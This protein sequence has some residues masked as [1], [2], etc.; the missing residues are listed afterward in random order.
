LLLRALT[1]SSYVHENPDAGAEDN[2]RLEFL[3]DAV[4]ELVAAESLYRAH[5]DASEGSLTLQRAAIASTG[6]LAALA[7]GVSLGQ[8][9]RLGRGVDKGGG[10]D[11]DSL[12]ANALEALFGAVYLDRGLEQARRLYE[13]LAASAQP[14]QRNY[15][16]RLQELTQGAGWGVPGY[17]LLEVTGPGHKRLHLVQVRVGERVLADGAGLTR[18]AAEQ[19]AARRALELLADELGGGSAATRGPNM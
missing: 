17:G 1:H 4:V 3:G 7:R 14:G 19:E 18:R 10:R 5:P 6:G 15:K 16:G 2:E 12:L 13:R 9:L 11:L 8:S